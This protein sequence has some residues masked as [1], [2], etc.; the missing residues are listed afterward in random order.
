MRFAEA[1]A[2]ILINVVINLQFSLLDPIL[3]L[4]VKRRDISQDFTGLIMGCMSA[5]YFVCPYYVT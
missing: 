1:I 3:P 2:V 4:E 5:G